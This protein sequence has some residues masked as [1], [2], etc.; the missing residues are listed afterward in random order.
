MA[1]PQLVA[2]YT[3]S[4]WAG[5]KATP[6]PLS[7]RSARLSAQAPAGGVTEAGRVQLRPPSLLRRMPARESVRPS[8]RAVATSTCELPGCTATRQAAVAKKL[9]RRSQVRPRSAVL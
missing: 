7:S 4:G 6:K 5:S 3:R 8:N 1:S 9:S 2:A